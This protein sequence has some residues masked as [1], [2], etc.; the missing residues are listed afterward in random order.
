LQGGFYG[1]GCFFPV[2]HIKYNPR[3]EKIE[4][5]ASLKSRIILKLNFKG[6]QC[7]TNPPARAV[8]D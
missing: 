5:I 1:A 6:G 4:G 8:P 7:R 3:L 2:S